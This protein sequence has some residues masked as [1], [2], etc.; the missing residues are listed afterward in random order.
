MITET[1][2]EGRIQD[3]IH[4]PEESEESR[5]PEHETREQ[6]H[7]PENYCLR[8]RNSLWTNSDDAQQTRLKKSASVN[9][10]FSQARPISPQELISALGD[11]GVTSEYVK[12]L[13]RAPQPGVYTVTFKDPSLKEQFLELPGFKCCENAALIQDTQSPLSFVSIRNA[14]PEL[15]DAAVIA[16]LKCFGNV[17]SFRRCLHAN[18]TIEKGT[19]TARMRLHSDI[20]SY[21]RIASETLLILY[22][23]QPR[24]CRRC[25]RTGHI[26]LECSSYACFN[27]DELGHVASVCPDHV[28]CSICKSFAHKAY[29]CPFAL[30]DDLNSNLPINAILADALASVLVPSDSQSVN[31]ST[32][33]DINSDD[34]HDFIDAETLDQDLSSGS[35]VLSSAQPS[36]GFTFAAPSPIA[37]LDFGTG[38]F[39]CY[40]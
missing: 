4:A 25:N 12:A 29:A 10:Q 39:S 21:I 24:T 8:D 38:L 6:P 5:A 18:S 33:D 14:P 3:D 23:H 26:A 2:L 31:D 19:R 37:T 32:N 34:G 28:R 27:C 22:D 15:P 36:T 11:Y 40:L 16:R 35:T 1:E 13:H 20:P 17:V 9:L 30:I 7:E